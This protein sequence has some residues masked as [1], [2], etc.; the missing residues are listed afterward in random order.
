MSE[1]HRKGLA[2][3]DS[4]ALVVETVTSFWDRFG[5]VVLGVVV[6]VIALGAIAYFT[7]QAN[8]RK[9]NAAAEKLAEANALFWNGDYDRSQTV[10]ADVVKLYGDTPNGNDARRV[11]GDAFYWKGKWKEAIEQYKAYLGKQGTGIVAQ[12][13]RRSLA[14]AYESDKQYA[15]AGKLY[16]GLVGVFERESSGEM[17]AASARCLEAANN[18]PEAAKRLQRLLDEF[19][20]TS[21]ANRARVKLAELQAPAAN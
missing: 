15:E 12:S 10:A 3:E 8:E 13:V 2:P 16:D 11:A 5:R 20:D 6:A 14:Y 21:Y 17:L 9:N 18:K 19:G 1:E 7:M 4:G